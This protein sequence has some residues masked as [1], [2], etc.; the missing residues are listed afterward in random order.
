MHYIDLAVMGWCTRACMYVCVT[1][2][3]EGAG[4]LIFGGVV[5]GGKY[6][7]VKMVFVTLTMT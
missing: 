6:K 2:S 3:A 5:V 7:N 4:K 1:K